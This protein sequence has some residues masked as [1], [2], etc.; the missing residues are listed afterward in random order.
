MK[1]EKKSCWL[2][3]FLFVLLVGLAWPQTG[4]D[5]AMQVVSALPPD[6]FLRRAVEGGRYGDGVEQPWQAAMRQV[7]VKAARVEVHMLWFFGPKELTAVRIVYYNSYEDS[8]QIT[9]PSALVR[10]RSSGLEEKVKAEAIRRAPE[11]HWVDLPHST[12]RPFRAATAVTVWD[13]PWL[14]NLPEMFTTFGPGLPPL[15]AAVGFGDLADVDRLLASGK[16][17]QKAIN[18]A[19]WYT[20]S[21][22]DATILQRLIKAGAN[23]NQNQPGKEF[24]T[25]LMIAIWSNAPEVVKVLLASGARVNGPQ[26]EYDETPL[27]LSASVPSQPTTIV[28]MLLGAGGDVRAANSYGITAVMKA[29]MRRPPEPP[30]AL[31]LLINHGADVNARDHIGRSAL[32]FAV[33]NGNI[34]TVKVLLAAHADVNVR[35]RQG[36][37]I[38]DVA[39]NK[40]IADL[41]L[42]AK[43]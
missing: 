35:D 23:V 8:G 4:R 15:V 28:K 2:S 25:C 20:C 7:G 13:D 42:A 31:E 14:P 16:I 6:N 10:I 19:L 9:D 40:Q 37:S 22:R 41:L 26:G 39:T 30:S 17:D 33:E 18:E 36:R 34:Q 27:T 38:S 43:E 29:S 32:W 24:G 21:D 1:V 3:A 5:H 11:G 12:F